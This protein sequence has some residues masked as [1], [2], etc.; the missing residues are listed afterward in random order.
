MMRLYIYM[1][2]RSGL[3]RSSRPTWKMMCMQCERMI[4]SFLS[5]RSG[6]KSKVNLVLLLANKENGR[7]Y[8]SSVEGALHG[9]VEIC[10][11]REI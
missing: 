6:W 2:S 4:C 9:A 10:G 7:V 1:F 5:T 11:K 3:I 8:S